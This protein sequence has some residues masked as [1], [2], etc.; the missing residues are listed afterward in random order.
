MV[1]ETNGNPN[2]ITQKDR[3]V[4]PEYQISCEECEATFVRET[5]RKRGINIAFLLCPILCHVLS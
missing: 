1:L 2:R 5:E 3:M 4:D